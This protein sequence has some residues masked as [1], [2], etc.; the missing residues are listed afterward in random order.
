VTGEN[1]SQ[2]FTATSNIDL[3]RRRNPVGSEPYIIIN[4]PGMKKPLGDADSQ[5][6]GRAHRV[7]E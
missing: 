7:S 3:Y 1:L 2:F 4:S 5:Q 6:N